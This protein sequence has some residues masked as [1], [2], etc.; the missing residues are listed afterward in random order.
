MNFPPGPDIDEFVLATPLRKP[1]AAAKTHR[2]KILN[3]QIHL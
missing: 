2:V 1:C 3:R